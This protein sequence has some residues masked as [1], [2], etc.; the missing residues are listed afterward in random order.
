MRTDLQ[1][2][3]VAIAVT[4]SVGWVLYRL[5]GMGPWL[6]LTLIS[7]ATA[8][9]TVPIAW[10]ELRHDREILLRTVYATYAAHDLAS[11]NED[12]ARALGLDHDPAAADAIH[13]AV[14]KPYHHRRDELVKHLDRNAVRLATV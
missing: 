10:E 3:V 11:H 8:V 7:A 12:L 1:R 14:L 6:A 2:L 4:A 5:G 9:A 13:G